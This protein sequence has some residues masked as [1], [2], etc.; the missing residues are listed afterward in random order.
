MITIQ[1]HPW[2]H[3]TGVVKLEQMKNLDLRMEYDIRA[4]GPMEAANDGF[5]PW[6]IRIHYPAGATDLVRSTN[7]YIWGRSDTW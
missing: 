1:F 2:S 4:T 6:L 3:L 7:A 5:R